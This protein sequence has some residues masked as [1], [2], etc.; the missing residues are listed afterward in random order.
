MLGKGVTRFVPLI[1]AVGV[2]AYAYFDTRQVGRTAMDLF[3]S[4]IMVE[5]IKPAQKQAQKFD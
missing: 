1:G 3:A 2:G 4:D 5:E